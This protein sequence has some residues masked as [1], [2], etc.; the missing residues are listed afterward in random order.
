VAYAAGSAQ[1]EITDNADDMMKTIVRYA[2]TASAT[3]TD[4]SWAA[5][6][7]TVAADLGHAPSISM[8]FSYRNVLDVLY[9]I[10]EASRENGTRLYFDVV[11]VSQDDG[12]LGW[13][14]R[15]YTGQPGA[16]R[17]G[18]DQVMFSPDF[19][20]LHN[21][22]L[23]FDYTDERNVIYAGG[24]GLET[25]RIVIEVEDAARAKAS[26]WARSEKFYNCSGQAE[27][28]AQVTAAGKGELSAHQPTIDFVGTL[29]DAPSTRF[30]VDWNFGD[31]AMVGYRGYQYEA[32]INLVSLKFDG[33]GKKTIS[34]GFEVI[35]D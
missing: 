29:T 27:T 14:F 2:A 28:T 34:A 22:D 24:R 9:D 6:G 21:A 1:A 5:N 26:P 19:G 18:A 32:V 31:L 17:T 15:T 30:A 10:A 13:Q 23:T 7:F 16:D 33:E 35:D 12:T 8:A 4:R 20:N 25:E 11:P 3:D